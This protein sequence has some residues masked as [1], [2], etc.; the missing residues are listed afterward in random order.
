MEDD[1]F[2]GKMEQEYPTLTSEF[3]RVQQHQYELFLRK[4]HDYG[5]ANISFGEDTTTKEGQ[6][7]PTMAIV[8]RMRDKMERLIN[9]VLRNKVNAVKYESVTD[10]FRDMSIYGVIAQVVENGKWIKG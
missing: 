2:V 5:L 10:S 4:H 1:G 7:I 3:K 8:I 6:R 9:L